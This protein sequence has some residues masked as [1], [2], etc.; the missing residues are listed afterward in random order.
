MVS[1]QRVFLHFSLQCLFSSAVTMA[2]VTEVASFIRDLFII[3]VVIP[4]I[5]NSGNDAKT[6]V[7]ENNNVWPQGLQGVT[8]TTLSSP[9]HTLYR[10]LYPVSTF[11]LSF[12]TIFELRRWVQCNQAFGENLICLAVETNPGMR[13]THP[14][15]GTKQTPSSNP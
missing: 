7:H 11:W 9:I 1:C 3:Y 6:Y 13:T 4:R 15:V 5:R 12:S 14:V 2:E 8:R 10:F